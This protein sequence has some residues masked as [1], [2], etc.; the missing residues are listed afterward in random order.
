MR[1]AGWHAF[2]ITTPFLIGVPDLYV[3]ASLRP[4][5]WIE[6][7]YIKS[8]TGKVPLTPMQRKFMRDEVKVGGRA[9]WAVCVNGQDL[10]AGCN[11]D[12]ISIGPLYW[13][14]HRAPGE[15]WN[16]VAL[17]ERII[18]GDVAT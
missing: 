17:L 2:K 14:Q 9:G 11:S 18:N 3:K 1:R 15:E 6:L 12:I 16:V 5:V 4:P 10:Y 13:L 8:E 7:K